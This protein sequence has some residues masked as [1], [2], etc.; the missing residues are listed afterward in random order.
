LKQIF[1]KHGFHIVYDHDLD[2]PIA[3]GFYFTIAYPKMNGGQLM[4]ELMYY[5]ISSISL[6]AT[7]SHQQGIRACTSFIK[8]NQYDLLEERLTLFEKHHPL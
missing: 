2:E 4:E 5:G 6:S 8:P 3:D 7:G 1:I